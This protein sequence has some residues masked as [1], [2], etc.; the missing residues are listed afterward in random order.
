[1]IK[2]HLVAFDKKPILFLAYGFILLFAIITFNA[3]YFSMLNSP[4]SVFSEANAEKAKLAIIID[5]FGQSRAGVNEMMEIDKPLTFAIMPFL[6]HSTEDA[7][8]AY[9][10]GHEVIIHLSMEPKVGKASWLGP[11]PIMATT[12]GDEIVKIVTDA[13]ENIPH[14][15]GA[16]I[17]MGSKASS[18]EPVMHTVL[19]VV[20]AHNGYFVDSKTSDKRV[21]LRLAFEKGIPCVEN[22]IFIDSTQSKV[23][24][25][26]QLKKAADYAINNKFA[27]AI[28]H[29]GPDGGV[30]TAQ[31]IREMLPVFEENGV[32]LVYV[33]D[34]ILSKYDNK[35]SGITPN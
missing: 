3:V 29:V 10:K 16:N 2:I 14:A 24:I 27:V 34:L 12:N 6:I 20:G 26:S 8:E 28:G 30:V 9:K 13:Y 4:A 25:K 32:E 7:E 11:R 1:V 15:M 5:D 18:S 35:K 17:H 31:A 22:N 21:P 23:K 19:N 33:S